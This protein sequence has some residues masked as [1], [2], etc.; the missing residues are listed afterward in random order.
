VLNV[1]KL[2]VELSLSLAKDTNILVASHL[3]DVSGCLSI[4]TVLVEVLHA[5]LASFRLLHGGFL[6][7]LGESSGHFLVVGGFNFC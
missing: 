3:L 2:F 1:I 7:G 6:L 4:G 5:G